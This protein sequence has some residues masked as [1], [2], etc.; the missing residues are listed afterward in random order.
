[1]DSHTSFLIFY[2]NVPPFRKPFRASLPTPLFSYYVACLTSHSLPSK[3]VSPT[4]A[5]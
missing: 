5:S 1:V 3:A 2:T 4:S